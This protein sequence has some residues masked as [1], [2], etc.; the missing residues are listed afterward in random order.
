[1]RAT[2]SVVSCSWAVFLAACGNALSEA[3]GLQANEALH[4]EHPMVDHGAV[5]PHQLPKDKL[6]FRA[7]GSSPPN[8]KMELRKGSL[9]DPKEWPATFAHTATRCTA[10]QVGPRAV[11][12]AAHCV[13]FREVKLETTA[14]DAVALTCQIPKDF[15]RDPDANPTLDVAVCI[16]AAPVER[17]RYETLSLEP[18]TIAS[19]S[20]VTLTG[21]GCTDEKPDQFGTLRFG[22]S[23]INLRPTGTS[24]LLRTQGGAA[25]CVGDSGGP[26]FVTKGAVTDRVQ[27]GVGYT[28]ETSGGDMTD[29][30]RVAALSFSPVANFIRGV[31]IPICGVNWQSTKCRRVK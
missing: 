2:R 14:G 24:G 23:T 1:M 11:I 13:R 3:D 5:E 15:L 18:E 12:T 31:A 17:V 25:L 30:S 29:Q 8:V 27:V 4:T 16:L 10:N 21:A 6:V 9:A 26:T 19:E 7:I 20:E 28:A 22:S